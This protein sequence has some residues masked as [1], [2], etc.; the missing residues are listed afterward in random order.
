MSTNLQ[1]ILRM[2]EALGDGEI[3]PSF[4]DG[5]LALISAKAKEAAEKI[6]ARLHA[7]D[8]FRRLANAT[9]L[10]MGYWDTELKNCA[11]NEAYALAFN[12]NAENMFGMP[13]REVV[14]ELLFEKKF[15]PRAKSARR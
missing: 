11:A 4:H 2:I 14:G 8:V 15:A 6:Q 12:L 13:M 7:N 1:E 10:V 5:E 3:P 9:S